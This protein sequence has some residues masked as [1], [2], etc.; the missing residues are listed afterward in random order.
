MSQKR[1]LIQG[2]LILTITGFLS[3]FLGFFYRIFLS[4]NFPS[5]KIGQYQ[6]IFPLYTLCYSFTSLGIQ[7]AISRTVAQAYSEHDEQKAGRTLIGGIFISTLLSC[8][9][10]I[11]LQKNAS[12]LAFHF[13][14][15]SSCSP[16][17]TAMSYTLPFSAIHSCICG[18]Y[19]GRRQTKIPSVAQ[20]IEQCCRITSVC[21]LYHFFDKHGHTP[22]I[23]IVVC[24]LVI[25][26][27]AAA[28]YCMIS[29]FLSHKT[30]TKHTRLFFPH[31]THLWSLL[32]LSL[33][34]T[35][36][37]VCI[38]LLQSIE[39]SS[40]PYK[41]QTANCTVQ[42]ALSIY[43]VLTG[44]AMPC[45]LC[46][47]AV[48]NSVALLLLPTIAEIQA[49]KEQD[50]L[51]SLIH[52]SLFTCFAL[53]LLFC[54]FFLFF[55][56]W[57]G[58]TFFHTPL[59]G[60]FITTLAWLCPFIY[61]NTTLLSILNGLGKTKETLF[62]NVLGLFLRIIGIHFIIP[63]QGIQGYLLTLLISHLCISIL[64]VFQIHHFLHMNVSLY[65]K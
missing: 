51:S 34:L 22:S 1:S 7:T 29:F 10:T 64:S 21:S 48:T 27:L 24:G 65:K 6:L 38:T 41:L 35:L 37:R 33:P 40:I 18:Y 14:H 12:L 60:Q 42:D 54:V 61:S 26:E 17:I 23:L 45:I 5:D 56:Q 50:K 16:F 58:T 44:M 59:A 43:G 62:I 32:K 4:R 49:K 47:S 25:G 57:I 9:C 19:Y 11:L 36:T 28:F 63:I 3:R 52:K 39:A 13:L 46:P 30:L 15:N 8:L 53:G 31:S 55:G 2:T 20:L